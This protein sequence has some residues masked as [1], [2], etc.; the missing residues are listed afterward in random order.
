MI[1]I[2]NQTRRSAEGRGGCSIRQ[3]LLQCLL[4]PVVPGMSPVELRLRGRALSLWRIRLRRLSPVTSLGDVS[5][6]SSYV[7]SLSL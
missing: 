2:N 1:R 3:C 7:L 6:L 4:S 5:L